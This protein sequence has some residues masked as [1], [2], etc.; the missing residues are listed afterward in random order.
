[1]N[2]SQPQ[3]SQWRRRLGI[4]PGNPFTPFIII[5]TV[6]TVV[7][8]VITLGAALTGQTANDRFI[9]GIVFMF[10][11][12]L[13]PIPIGLLILAARHYARIQDVKAGNYW[14]HWQYP[15][16]SETPELF[17]GPDGLYNPNKPLRLNGFWSGLQSVD[18]QPGEPSTLNFQ[19]LS[20]RYY[21]AGMPPLTSN[22]VFT[23][24]IPAGKEQE[25]EA[26]IPTFKQLLGQPSN[27][28]NEQWRIGWIM[29]GAIMV[30]VLLS[31]VLLL[32]LQFQY[33]DAKRA[34]A[35]ATRTMDQATEIAQVDVLS[36]PIRAVI[37]KQIE[38]LKTLP[39]GKMTAEEAGFDSS[40]GVSAV[41]YGHCAPDN[42]FY[43]YVILT[44]EALGR[45]YL[46]GPGAFNYTTATDRR[47]MDCGPEHLISTVPDKLDGGW[48]YAVIARIASTRTP[49]IIDTATPTAP[50]S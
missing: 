35:N 22:K 30:F 42:A 46:G 14:L 13:S 34:F 19:Y 10:V 37:E 48:Y 3:T 50:P 15:G 33:D 32:P 29:S 27:A 44:Q 7:A 9:A 41:Y 38:R 6:L 45:R 11:G 5:I 20:R 21:S 31:I 39:D 23:V 18:I 49:R 4:T 16:D 47:Y 8:L 28:L 26:A 1:M 40:A 36:Q 24:P 12:S 17:I 2:T 25:A 43:L